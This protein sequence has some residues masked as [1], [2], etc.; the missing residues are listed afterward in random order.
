MR[1]RG[2]GRL[3]YWLWRASSHAAR[4][5]VAFEGAAPSHSRRPQLVKGSTTPA[6]AAPA[7]SASTQHSVGSS[8][9]RQESDEEESRGRSPPGRKR[10]RSQAEAL[11]DQPH[12][13]ASKR[14]YWR[15]LGPQGCKRY[16]KPI[17]ARLLAKDE[18][19]IPGRQQMCKCMQCLEAAE[20][21]C[22]FTSRPLPLP[23][24][25]CYVEA[26]F[27]IAAPRKGEAPATICITTPDGRFGA[28]LLSKHSCCGG[29]GGLRVWVS[30]C[31]STV[32]Q[33]RHARYSADAI[34][35][36][37]PAG[38]TRR[39]LFGGK[40]PAAA[41]CAGSR[42]CS[43]AWGLR[44]ATRCASSRP[45]GA[46][47]RP[48]STERRLHRCGLVRD[49]NGMHGTESDADTQLRMLAVCRRSWQAT[50]AAARPR[51]RR[52][53]R[54]AAQR[55]MARPAACPQARQGAAP[56]SRRQPA[57]CRGRAGPWNACW[58]RRRQQVTAA[59]AAM[60]GQRD[61]R[62]SSGSG[63]C[64]MQPVAVSFSPATPRPLPGPIYCRRA[65][66]RPLCLPAL[67]CGAALPLPAPGAPRHSR[68]LCIPGRLAAGAG[69]DGAGA[70]SSRQQC[71]EEG[72]LH[73]GAL[74]CGRMSTSMQ[75]SIP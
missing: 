57:C 54:L 40:A 37:P 29:R 71:T 64:A 11:P 21:L 69:L 20:L 16:C 51:G 17:Q 58:R 32:Q 33:W 41:S 36:L 70:L 34:W 66:A 8:G 38:H 24:A 28:G 52:P 1:C 47:S 23:P 9:G 35:R 7:S 65:A 15:G 26:A 10:R 45:A 30:G 60:A 49:G 39:W 6:P 63:A 56:A 19:S 48:P 72:C 46:P 68:G 25:G 14:T 59:A 13:S 55:A 61:G 73:V 43:T 67:V 4:A 62:H 44:A 18:V 53:L 5:F 74:D 3:S 75:H 27:G 22:P 2:P 42:A 12:E 31:K 50:V